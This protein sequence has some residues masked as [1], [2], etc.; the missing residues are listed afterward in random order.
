M[1][2]PIRSVLLLAVAGALSFGLAA[3]GGSSSNKTATATTA[4]PAA[5]ATTAAPTETAAPAAAATTVHIKNF[6]F[7]PTPLQVKAGQTITVVNDDTVSHTFTADG[8]GFDS[9]TIA[10]GASATVTVAG[11]GSVGY[12]CNIHTTMKGSLQVA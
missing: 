7:S 4:A 9:G 6:A 10:A 8:G 5:P 12:H 1:M 2:R 11:T 3:C